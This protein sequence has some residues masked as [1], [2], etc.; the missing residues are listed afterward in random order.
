MKVESCDKGVLRP[1][2]EAIQALLDHASPTTAT[3]VVSLEQALGRVLAEPVD[4]PLDLPPWDNSAMDGY[5]VRADDLTD[6]GNRLQIAQRIIAGDYSHETLAPGQAARIFTGAPLPAGADTVV[7]QEDCR[8]EEGTVIVPVVSKGS[9]VRY[10]GEEIHQGESVLSAGQRLQPVQLGLLASLGIA[11]VKVYQPLR[12]TVLSS[13]NELRQPGDSLQPGQIYNANQYSVGGILRSLGF[14]VQTEAVIADNE[15]AT[16]NALIRAAG[17]C[18]VLITSG[19]V[20]VGEEDHLKAVIEQLGTLHLW[21]LA[22]QPGKPFAFGTI[23]G[24]PWL[25]LPGNPAAA[26]ITAMIVARPFLLRL[27][28]VEQVMAKTLMLPAD[29]DWPQARP[30][31]QYLRAR[32]ETTKN[33]QVTHVTLHSKQSSAMLVAASWADGL[34][35]VE[36]GRT[37]D[38]GDDVGFIPFS[39][40]LS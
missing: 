9:H 38:A 20:S 18:D 5:A 34:A 32:L 3:E 40:L 21:R 15:E 30:R 33:G 22:I 13:G 23:E 39:A 27:Q 24:S 14:L 6:K 7:A 37:F 26:V 28:G 31:R 25:G 12:I 4:A 29:F 16:R 1:V 10:R 19:G 11:E 36:R 35:V 17:Q 8:L 2:D